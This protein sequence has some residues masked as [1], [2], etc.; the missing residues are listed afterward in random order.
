[1]AT[2]RKTQQPEGMGLLKALIKKEVLPC[3]CGQLT[4]AESAKA[5]KTS[6]SRKAQNGDLA[7]RRAPGS[8]GGGEGSD[9]KT[10]LTCGGG[11][12]GRG[13]RG[14][15][16]QTRFGRSENSRVEV[17]LELVA[18]ERFFIS[19]QTPNRILLKEGLRSVSLLGIWGGRGGGGG[20]GG[21]AVRG[22]KGGT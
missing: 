11:G 3:R 9:K 15:I 7:L 12:E 19:S 22:K 16:K 17:S 13:Q 20:V 10:S 4:F 5:V 21:G 1:L 2:V 6:K 8:S 18:F 14:P